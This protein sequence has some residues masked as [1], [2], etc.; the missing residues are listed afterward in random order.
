MSSEQPWRLLNVP[1][2]VEAF[3]TTA[4]NDRA[5]CRATPGPSASFSGRSRLQRLQHAPCHFLS[6][7]ASFQAIFLRGASFA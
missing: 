6:L 1:A 5:D 7:C 3:C 2:R 4:K